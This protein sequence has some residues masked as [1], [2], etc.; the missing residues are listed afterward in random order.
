MNKQTTDNI[1]I[2]VTSVLRDHV[3]DR[4]QVHSGRLVTYDVSIAVMHWR[5]YQ[6]V[7]IGQQAQQVQ[8]RQRSVTYC[9]DGRSKLEYHL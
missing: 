3:I 6:V 4:E 8:C 9:V 7:V 1:C 2:N 5:W